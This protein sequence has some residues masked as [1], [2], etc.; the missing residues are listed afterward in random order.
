MFFLYASIL[1][2]LR[3]HAPMIGFGT[4][5][6]HGN[7]TKDMYCYNAF[8]GIGR[9]LSCSVGRF[10]AVTSGPVT[11]GLYGPRSAAGSHSSRVYGDAVAPATHYLPSV[12]AAGE[13]AAGACA[14]S[15]V[16][17]ATSGGGV[18]GVVPSVEA[19]H[20]EFGPLTGATSCSPTPRPVTWRLFCDTLG[21]GV[22]PPALSFTALNAALADLPSAL[23]ALDFSPPRPTAGAALS[24]RAGGVSAGI[25]PRK[26]LKPNT[27][28]VYSL[29]GGDGTNAENVIKNKWGK[30]VPKYAPSISAVQQDRTTG[31]G[32]DY[33]TC[34]DTVRSYVLPCRDDLGK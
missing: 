32:S 25:S 7:S 31:G 17:A 16:T 24:A 4:S 1:S 21:S 9:K 15:V 26:I 18:A 13:A 11:W 19:F 3:V 23:S 29:V 27:L 8:S 34:S 14:A 5:R 33:A 28:G 10:V 2:A 12:T 6:L 20:S 22:V 30:V